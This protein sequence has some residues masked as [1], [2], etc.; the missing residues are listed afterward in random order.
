MLCQK[1]SGKCETPLFMAQL[2]DAI[3]V[4]SLSSMRFTHTIQLKAF[5]NSGRIPEFKTRKLGN[6]NEEIKKVSIFS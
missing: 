5:L 4:S 2:K 1:Q 3:E 6:T